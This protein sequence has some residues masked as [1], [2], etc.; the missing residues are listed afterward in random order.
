MTVAVDVHVYVHRTVRMQSLAE[1]EATSCNATN[2]AQQTKAEQRGLAARYE[3]AASK[4][5]R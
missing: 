1:P 4:S 3:K 5:P 2:V